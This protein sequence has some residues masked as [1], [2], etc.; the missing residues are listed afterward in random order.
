[1]TDPRQVVKKTETEAQR[2]TESSGKK[3]AIEGQRDTIEE[4]ET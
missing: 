1:M 4:E 2:E 3:E